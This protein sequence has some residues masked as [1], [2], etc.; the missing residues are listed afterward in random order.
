MMKSK[1]QGDR[2]G[3]RGGNPPAIVAALLVVAVSFI[4]WRSANAEDFDWRNIDGQDFTTPTRVQ[5][6]STCWAYAAVGALEAKYKITRNDPSFSLDFSESHVVYNSGAGTI[7]SGVPYLALDWIQNTGV[8]LEPDY[9]LSTSWQDRVGKLTSYEYDL[10]P[11]VYN[12]KNYLK[13]YGPLAVTIRVDNDWYPATKPFRAWHAVSIVGFHDDPG[14]PEGGYWIVKNSWAA[15]NDWRQVLYGRGYDFTAITGAVYYTAALGTATWDTSTD[16]GFQGS[17]GVWST[18]VN[19][20]S[21]DGATRQM[22]RNGEDAAVFAAGGIACPVTI[23]GTISAHSLT[24]NAGATGYTF[25]GGT[26]IVTAGGIS[27]QE[28]LTINSPLIIG[29]P[30]QWSV[31]AGKTL[32][33][34]GNVN[35]NFSS[36][37][38]AGAGNTDINSP[39]NGRGGLSKTGGGVLTLAASNSFSG[40]T[41]ILEGTLKLAADAS[42]P[43]PLIDMKGGILDVSA[44]GGGYT[45]DYNQTL[46]G[47]GTIQGPMTV[48]GYLTTGDSPAVHTVGNIAFDSSSLLE[49]MLGGTTLGDGYDK[50]VSTGLLDLRNNSNLVVSFREDSFSYTAQGGL[51][52]DILDFSSLSGQFSTVDLPPL[53]GGLSWDSS[54]LYVDGTISIVPEPTAIVLLA[55]GGLSIWVAA[56]RRRSA[57]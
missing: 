7:D 33:I 52:F 5:F 32:T 3:R 34:G 1:K 36:L 2:G 21:A 16:S 10:N 19:S 13:T 47:S 56:G 30:Q 46:R 8:V 6:A 28:N 26:L 29:A 25:T 27:T 45:L 38:V 23:T 51:S 37:T 53:Y 11:S 49:I 55:I 9:P 14:I 44:L 31:A 24:F 39:I 12:I 17:G 54:H 40:N 20:W 22:W 4:T 15:D 50:L 18:G 43:S 35:T 48:R 41:A 57:R 42:L